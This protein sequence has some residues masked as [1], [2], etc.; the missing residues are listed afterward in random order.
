MLTS[1]G[2]NPVHRR[3]TGRKKGLMIRVHTYSRR[4]M[5]RRQEG[6]ERKSSRDKN[7]GGEREI[8]FSTDLICV[9]EK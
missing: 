8:L 1:L 5:K 4:D 6:R 3:Q 7:D 2:D 9:V